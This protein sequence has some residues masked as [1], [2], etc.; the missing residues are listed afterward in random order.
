[1][2]ATIA[3]MTNFR[4]FYCV[5]FFSLFFVLT[6]F[7]WDAESLEISKIS[8]LD[9]GAYLCIGKISFKFSTLIL[10]EFWFSTRRDAS[11]LS[12]EFAC[13]MLSYPDKSCTTITVRASFK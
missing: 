4:L 1:M 11:K 10:E 7:E 5:I 8:R 6:V 12:R 3:I 9:M 13:C 2:K